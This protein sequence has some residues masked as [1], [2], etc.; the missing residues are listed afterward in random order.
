MTEPIRIARA[1]QDR[2]FRR[3]EIATGNK[4]AD[5]VEEYELVGLGWDKRDYTINIDP[6]TAYALPP[7]H[8][9]YMTH[10]VV[11]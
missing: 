6:G 10:P 7:D 2:I 3:A 9:M 11:E 5:R 8:K 1:V 4:E